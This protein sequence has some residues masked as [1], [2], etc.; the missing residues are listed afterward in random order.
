MVRDDLLVTSLTVGLG[1]ETISIIRILLF[2]LLQKKGI[3]RDER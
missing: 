2:C 1:V 3:F